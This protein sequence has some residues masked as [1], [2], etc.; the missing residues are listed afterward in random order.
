MKWVYGIN[1]KKKF[2]KVFDNLIFLVLR[3]YVWGNVFL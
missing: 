3:W 2:F 1:E